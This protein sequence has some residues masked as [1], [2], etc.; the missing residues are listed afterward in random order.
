MRGNIIEDLLIGYAREQTGA[1]FLDQE[2]LVVADLEPWGGGVQQ[3]ATD[4]GRPL[5]AA[6]R[7]WR[8]ANLA[9]AAHGHPDANPDA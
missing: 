9:T 6:N 8:D 1:V 7:R 2:V 4:D 5:T 3:T